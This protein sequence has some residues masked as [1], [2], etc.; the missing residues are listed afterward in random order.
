MKKWENFTKEELNNFVKNSFSY[1][2]LAEKI[3]YSKIGGS[4]IKSLK[5]MI[6]FY[7]FDISHFKGQ[8]WNKDNFDY[9]RFQKG[10]AIRISTALSA[11]VALRGHRCEKCGLSEWNNLPITLEIHHKDGDPLNNDLSNLELNCPNCHSQTENWR[12]KNINKKQ[13]VISD[14]VF[15]QALKEKPNIR[16]ALLSLG[17]SAKGGNYVRARELIQKY[18]IEHLL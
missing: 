2:Q 4:S 9:E 11:I 8:A 6:E 12:G 14:D 3:G 10:K 5:T 13:D 17:L 7:N 18:N 1:A 16:Q 15:V